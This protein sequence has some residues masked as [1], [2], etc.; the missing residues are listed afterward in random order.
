MEQLYLPGFWGQSWENPVFISSLYII[1]LTSCGLR[2]F[3][4]VYDIQNEG[5]HHRGSKVEEENSNKA[6]CG[7]VEK[8]VDVDLKAWEWNPGFAT[9]GVTKAGHCKGW[10]SLSVGWEV[11][12]CEGPPACTAGSRA[13]WR[14]PRMNLAWRE[15]SLQ[16]S[17]CIDPTGLAEKQ[18]LL[19]RPLTEESGHQVLG[20]TYTWDLTRWEEEE[21]APERANTTFLP[22]LTQFNLGGGKPFLIPWVHGKTKTHYDF[23]IEHFP[24]RSIWKHTEKEMCTSP[25]DI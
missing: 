23:N 4:G 18:Q 11:I 12:P 3:S 25:K 6:S 8:I 19:R 10:G 24:N 5:V 15:W 14:C 13:T 9:F 2:V 17:L 21:T 20:Y 1:H 16:T 7:K 22:T